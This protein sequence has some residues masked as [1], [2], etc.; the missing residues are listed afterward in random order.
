[1]TNAWLLLI[2]SA[3]EEERQQKPKEIKEKL[4]IRPDE[5]NNPQ[6]DSR[7][8][9]LIEVGLAAHPDGWTRTA[10]GSEI[11]HQL[12]QTLKQYFD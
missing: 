6:L 8:N 1:M 11:V 4:G 7:L 3:L 10:K 9:K 12:E 2:L 5:R